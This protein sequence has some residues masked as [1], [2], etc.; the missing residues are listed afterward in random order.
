[1]NTNFKRIIILAVLSV[2]LAFVFAACGRGNGDGDN[3]AQPDPGET[4]NEPAQQQ[5]AEPPVV[6]VTV[7]DVFRWNNF[8]GRD[9]HNRP[10]TAS[11]GLPIWWDNWANMRTSNV[12]DGVQIEFRPGAFD[13]EDFDDYD[14]FF[15]RAADWMGNWGEAIDMWAYDGISYCRYI[16]IRMRGVVGGE[17]LALMLHFQPNDGPSFVARF[18]DLTLRGGGNPQITTEMQDIVID[19]EASGFPGMTNRMHIRAFAEAS[20][21]L[22]EIYFSS[23]IELIDTTSNETIH[24]GFLVEA[25]GNPADLPIRQFMNAARGVF[26]WNGFVGR[27]PHNRPALSA[28]GVPIWWD[29]WANLRAATVDDGV[30]IEFRPGAFDPEDFDDYDDFFARAMDWMGNWGEAVDM[31]ALDNISFCRYLTIRMRGEQGGEENRIL[32]HFQPNDGPVFAARFSDLT[33]RGGGSPQIT[34]EMQDIV[35]D[36]QASGFPGMTNR[37]HIRAFA[38]STIVL[39]E[40]YF[41]GAIAPIDTDSNDTIHA[42]F[43]VTETVDPAGLPLRDF[44]A[45]LD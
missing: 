14:D 7:P 19:L 36:L 40:I 23:P 33:V 12:D 16:T 32:L 44:I 35:I 34:T 37:M 38:E 21:V 20:I 31:W 18:S 27:D 22:H 26:P 3:Q 39:N 41:H 29:N 15:A 13:P 10:E 43:T 11:N 9:P 6:T 5:P 4:V 2:L 42:G 30:Q 45:E 17:E 8:V 24:A 25:S 1:M 28:G